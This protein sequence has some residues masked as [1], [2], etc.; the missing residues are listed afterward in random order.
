MKSFKYNKNSK[1]YQDAINEIQNHR[2]IHWESIYHQVQQITLLK[3]VHSILEFGPGRGLTGSILKYYGHDY[4]SCDLESPD[5]ESPYNHKFTK[6]DFYSSILDFKTTNK[7]DLVCAFEVLEHN[8]LEEFQSHIVKLAKLSRKYIYLSLPYSGRWISFTLNINLPK[9]RLNFS[10]MFKW[11]RIISPKRDI[12]NYLKLKKPF[13]F[14]DKHWFEF[15]DKNFK[16]KDIQ[17]VFLENKLNLIETFHSQSFPMH[18]FFL[19][20]K[21]KE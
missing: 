6:P 9:L 13:P 21:I 3:D 10:K 2:K 4:M 18:C 20:S 17:K 19:L 5:L 15:G 16:M 11:D 14:H 8:P 12:K 7:Y 1:F